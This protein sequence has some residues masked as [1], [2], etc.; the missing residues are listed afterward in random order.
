MKREK[1]STEQSCGKTEIERE[2]GK[3][4]EKEKGGVT[5]RPAYLF[6]GAVGKKEQEWV[7]IIS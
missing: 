1:G 2:G 7:E 3:E 5:Q 6:R 4:R